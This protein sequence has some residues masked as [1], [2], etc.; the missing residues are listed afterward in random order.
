MTRPTQTAKPLADPDAPVPGIPDHVKRPNPDPFNPV[1]L[2]VSMSSKQ[3]KMEAKRRVRAAK[4]RLRELQCY[5][6][7]IFALH[8]DLINVGGYLFAVVFIRSVIW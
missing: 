7:A 4:R 5:W 2:T 1:S 6:V 3:R 8:M